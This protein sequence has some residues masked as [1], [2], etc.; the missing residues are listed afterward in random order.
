MMDMILPSFHLHL[1]WY[2]WLGFVAL[3]LGLAFFIAVVAALSRGESPLKIL[4]A[5]S[6]PLT[7]AFKGK[8]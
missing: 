1:A 6:K 4:A 7:A 2:D 5:I 3:I 8:K